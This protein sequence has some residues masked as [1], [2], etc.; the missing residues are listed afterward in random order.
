MDASGQKAA[1]AEDHRPGGD[2]L[3]S[4]LWRPGDVIADRFQLALPQDLTPGDYTLLAGF[5]DPAT[6]ERVADPLPVG[7]VIIR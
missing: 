7:V 1:Q 4:T 3:P 2:Y 6:G 5:Y